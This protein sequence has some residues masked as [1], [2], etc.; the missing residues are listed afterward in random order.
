MRTAMAFMA[1]AMSLESPAMRLT[2]T[3]GAGFISNMV[4]TG[5]GTMRITS[6]WMPKSFRQVMRLA[7]WERS[8]SS[9]GP[10]VCGGGMVSS[11]MGG[12]PSAPGEGRKNG[13]DFGLAG[14]S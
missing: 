4:T 10:P 12:S 5:P 3:P 13:F 1:R 11:S 6:P 9:D 7:A 14:F 8:M 2:F